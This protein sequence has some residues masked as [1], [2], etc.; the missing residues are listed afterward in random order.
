MSIFDMLLANAMGE[1][2]G[3]GGGSSDFS[4]AT[5]TVNLAEDTYLNLLCPLLSQ[6][7]T[8]SV[9]D[10][11]WYDAG[12][13]TCTAILYK[14]VALVAFEYNGNIEVSDGVKY[15]SNEDLYYIDG[16][17]TIALTS[18]GGGD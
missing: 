9:S 3:G 2:G 15:D 13:Y 12:T 4:T 1:S 18:G 16:D 14:G 8:A 7:G 10:M 17:G 5:V 6:D 11:V